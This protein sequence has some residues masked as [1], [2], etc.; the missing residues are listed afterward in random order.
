MESN[1]YELLV[2]TF[3]SEDGAQEALRQLQS[4][5]KGDDKF[6]IEEAAALFV[7]QE[8]KLTIK[9]TGDTR[10]GKGAAIG[11]VV[12]GAIGLIGGPL[13][14]ATGALGAA[15]G[16]GLA[17]LSDGGFPDEQLKIIGHSLRPGM[18]A[19][20]VLAQMTGEVDL[21]AAIASFGAHSVKHAPLNK[22]LL[23]PQSNAGSGRKDF[24]EMAAGATAVNLMGEIA[25][26][27]NQ[28]P[29]EQAPQE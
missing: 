16:G 27:E 9:E 23:T 1:L 3:T 29:V 8:E 13:A 12:G 5:D 6:K 2:A 4:L 21:D 28:P 17:S 14:I 24:F 26:D 18:S 15:I 19:L 7:N 25:R 20:V 22:A 11:A 10:G